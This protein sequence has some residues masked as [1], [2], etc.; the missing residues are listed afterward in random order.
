M[1]VLQI[2]EAWRNRLQPLFQEPILQQL[3]VNLLVEKESFEVYPP[4]AKIFAAFNF[5]PWEKVK[6]VILGQDPY[7]GHGQANGLCFSV[8]KDFR[9]L[10]PSLK[11]IYKELKRDL[12]IP[13]CSH[14]DLSSWARQGVLLLNNVLTV[15]RASP[16]SH[17]KLGWEYLTDR[18]VEM[19]SHEKEHLVFLLWGSS[20]RK[21]AAGVNRQKHLVLESAHPSPLSC[22]RG[23]A[24]CGHFSR[25]NEYLTAHGHSPIHW[26]PCTD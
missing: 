14:G 15:R 6:V 23:F 19:L 13:I 11:N 26:D 10:P 7:H 16:Q 21:K 5:T 25:V 12:D 1:S 18:V 4:N 22:H 8:E 2:E 17:Q 20:A 3:K 24:G 9:P